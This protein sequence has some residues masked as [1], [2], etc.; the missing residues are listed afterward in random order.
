MRSEHGSADNKM[1]A[2]KLCYLAIPVLMALPGCGMGGGGGGGGATDGN[3][4][5]VS[6]NVSPGRID[7]GDRTRVSIVIRDFIPEQNDGVIVKIRFP[8]GLSYVAR[9]AISYRN[10]DKNGVPV[11]ANLW[12]ADEA[13]YLVIFWQIPSETAKARREIS[14]L[15]EGSYE[16]ENGV[17]EVDLDREDSLIPN[18]QEFDVENPQFTPLAAA[19]IEVVND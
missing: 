5:S 13:N 11:T 4:A 16:V 1:K 2:I 12:P 19:G 10:D 8:S 18:D 9:S 14:L 15:L 3:P 17:I 7:S 6:L